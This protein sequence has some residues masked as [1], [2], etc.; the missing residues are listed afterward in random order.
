MR[1]S[2]AGTLTRLGAYRVNEF[3]AFTLYPGPCIEA[4][5]EVVASHPTGPGHAPRHATIDLMRE[6][7]GTRATIHAELADVSRCIPTQWIWPRK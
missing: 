5:R 3:V 2:N 1:L 7:G 6:G 4:T